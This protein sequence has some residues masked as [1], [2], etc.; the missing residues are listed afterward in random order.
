[1]KITQNQKLNSLQRKIILYKEN[2]FFIS[3][4][5]KLNKDIFFKIKKNVSLF[6]SNF[7]NKKIAIKFSDDLNS[8]TFIPILD[9]LVKSL[10]ILPTDFS[11]EEENELL[12]KAKIKNVLV[13]SDSLIKK[14]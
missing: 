8:A 13:D 2:E 12:S 9:G 6:L 14:K 10:L 7:Q 5:G 11:K 3:K 1:M 4:S